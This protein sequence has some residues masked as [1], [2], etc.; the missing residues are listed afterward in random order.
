MPGNLVAP[1]GAAELLAPLAGVLEQLFR[2]SGNVGGS[3]GVLTNGEQHFLGIRSRGLDTPVPPNEDTVYLI[4][5]LTKPLLGLAIAVLVDGDEYDVT[6]ETPV[7][8]F[9]PGLDGKT[10]LRHT[11]RAATIADFL[12]HR[13]EF[14]RTTNLWESLGGAIPWKTIEPILSLL[15]HLPLSD[16]FNS[17][18][19]FAFDRN[20]SNEAFALLTAV[21]EKATDTPWGRFVETG[22]HSFQAILQHLKSK[23]STPQPVK[24]HPSQVSSSSR[25][26]NQ[27]LLGAAAGVQSTASDLIKFYQ[28]YLEM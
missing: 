18:S 19:S 1:E 13:S 8:R 2:V 14:L 15:R 22:I 27:T 17:P 9:L 7:Q 23:P 10:L 6:F 5:S 3:I 24:I 28:K 4:S 25:T 26:Y 20:Y 11:S 21:I 12:D 16:K